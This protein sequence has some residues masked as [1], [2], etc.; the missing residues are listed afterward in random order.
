M[1]LDTEQAAIVTALE[2]LQREDLDIEDEARQFAY[3]LEITGLSQRKLADK[4][5]INYNYLSRRVRLLKRPDL[6][7]MYQSGRSK[8]HEVLSMLDQPIAGESGQGEPELIE[9]EDM[10]GY[11]VVRVDSVHETGGGRDEGKAAMFRWRPAMQFRNWLNRTNVTAI[12]PDERASFKAQITEIK[13]K[14]DEW[15]KALSEASEQENSE[16]QQEAK[17]AGEEDTPSTE[18]EPESLAS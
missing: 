6:L 11:I 3:L 10:P 7:E 16:A 8:L 1:H 13:A 17:P 14:L 2:N 4:L 12:P 15:E 18:G 5:G 9:R